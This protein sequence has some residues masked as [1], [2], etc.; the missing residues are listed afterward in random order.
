MKD[1][2]KITVAT[3][4][5][6]V[7]QMVYA[8]QIT[9]NYNTG[10]TLTATTLNN[11]KN[12]VN[13]KQDRVIGSCSPGEAIRIIAADGN[14]TCEADDD[15]VPAIDS[16]SVGG[17]LADDGTAADPVLRQADGA[18]NVTWLS[19]QTT[20]SGCVVEYNNDYA[21]PS[22]SGGGSCFFRMPVHFPDGATLTSMLCNASVDVAKA[23][24]SFQLQRVHIQGTAQNLIFR[25]GISGQGVGTRENAFSNTVISGA[26]VNNGT[27][28]YYIDTNYL[29]ISV[30]PGEFRFYGCSFGYSY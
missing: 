5:L 7:F 25:A 6:F 3:G 11:I 2:I 19:M 4:L 23:G 17:G 28:L 10:D 24:L 27:Y 13:S 30:D 18:V 1:K 16:I 12:A 26:L 21:A 22:A 8:E 15:T 20:S 9:D 14:V 29:A